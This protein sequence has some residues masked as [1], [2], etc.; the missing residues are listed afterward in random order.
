MVGHQTTCRAKISLRRNPSG[1]P[2]LR[3]LPASVAGHPECDEALTVQHTVV[4]LRFDFLNAKYTVHGTSNLHRP[5]QH[6]LARDPVSGVGSFPRRPRGPL[7][8]RTQAPNAISYVFALF[9]FEDLKHTIG[10]CVVLVWSGSK[11]RTRAQT[12]G[13]SDRRHHRNLTDLFRTPHK[14]LKH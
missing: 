10:V 4:R 5:H 13:T 11:T 1:V 8:H 7:R 6:F 2:V 3:R 14:F 12:E 9:T